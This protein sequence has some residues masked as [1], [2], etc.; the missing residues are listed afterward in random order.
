MNLAGIACSACLLVCLGAEAGSPEFS[1]EVRRTSFGIPHVKAS[2]EAGLGYGIGYAYAQDNFCMFQETILT[3]NGARSRYFGPDAVGGPDVESGSIN[4]SNLR[5]DFFFRLLNAPAQVE[6]AWRGQPASVKA[7][8][9]GYAAGFNRFLADAGKQQLPA[10][11]RDAQWVRKI[12]ERD[13]IKFMRRMAVE[14]SSLSNMKGLLDAAPPVT[15]VADAPTVTDAHEWVPWADRREFVGS[16]GVA[17][18]KQATENGRGLLLGNPHYPWYGSLRFY[19]LHLTIPGKLDVMGASL[20]GFPVVNIGF[21]QQLAW[22][23]TVNTSQHFTVRTL[24]LDPRDA[25][26]YFVDGKS[27]RMRKQTVVVDVRDGTGAIAQRSHDFW[28]SSY[29][30]LLVRPGLSWNAQTAYAL[31][32]PNWNND[33]LLLTWHA[34]NVASSLDEFSDAITS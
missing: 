14:G 21:N 6:A 25:T 16:N 7:L 2:D 4:Q 28:I 29:G 33:R 5:S 23:H 27:R 24:R 19:Q 11:C 8:L 17:L 22:T 32:D 30:P 18:G 26:R 9:R 1:A 12:D 10:E 20:G 3:V 31:D 34:M 15:G 13:L